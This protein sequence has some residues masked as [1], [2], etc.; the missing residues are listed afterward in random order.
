MKFYVLS[1]CSGPEVLRLARQRRTGE[2]AGTAET[3]AAIC[4]VESRNLYLEAGYSSLFEYCMVDLGYSE[5]ATKKRIHATRAAREHADLVFP[6]LADG[7]LHLSGLV[8]LAPHLTQEN[9]EEL[10]AA[11][12]NQSKAKIEMLLVQ[13]KPKPDL[14]A[15]IQPLASGP[16]HSGPAREGA[17]GHVESGIA[18]SLS[19]V[20]LFEQ[21]PAGVEQRSRTI[22]LAPQR[23]GYQFSS[24]EEF[25]TDLTEATEL[26]GDAV[27]PGDLAAIFKRVLKA[28]LPVLRKQKFGA[29]KKP[30]RCRAPKPGSRRIP[31]SVKRAVWKRDGGRCTY[32]SD[33][34]RR[35]TSRKVQYDHIE[36]VARGGLS[37]ESNVRLLCHAHNQLAAEKTFGR[38]FMENKRDRRSAAEPHN[39]RAEEARVREITDEARAQAI[40]AVAAV[41]AMVEAQNR[42]PA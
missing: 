30:G 2:R 24:D 4:E 26:L 14:P 31:N 6:A 23:Y 33:D 25:Q 13:R 15:W 5:D 19:P 29:A 18:G 28:A 16:L 21:A 22:P 11:A 35:C 36:E 3:L 9:A 32:V 42:A 40:A 12:A 37:T 38:D 8:L 20:A 27:A 41:A 39:A 7:R 1:H 10:L 17:P 34:G